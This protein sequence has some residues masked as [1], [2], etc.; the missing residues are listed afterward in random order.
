MRLSAG[1]QPANAGGRWQ[2]TAGRSASASTS[3]RS[4]WTCFILLDF[5][6]QPF[7]AFDGHELPTEMCNY[8]TRLSVQCGGSSTD[9]RWLAGIQFV[10]SA[11]L[12]VIGRAAGRD[13]QELTKRIEWFGVADS[14]ECGP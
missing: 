1:R 5:N 11:P 7:T 14:D 12:Q 6:V 2:R 3:E 4:E 10:A 8:D 13:G 9:V